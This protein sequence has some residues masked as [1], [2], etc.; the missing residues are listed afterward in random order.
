MTE[1]KTLKDLPCYHEA[2]C[3]ERTDLK[4][5]AIKWIREL[6]KDYK[7]IR[8][9]PKAYR[10]YE[11]YRIDH[12]IPSHVSKALD[13]ILWIKHFFNITEDE[14]KEKPFTLTKRTFPERIRYLMKKHEEGE[15]DD[16]QLRFQLEVALG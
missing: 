9:N 10:D 14:L 12:G 11:Q 2:D 1:L 5:E 15:L 6:D 4:Q 7:E 16:D 13:Q 3:A 8:T